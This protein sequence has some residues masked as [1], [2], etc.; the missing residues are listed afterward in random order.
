MCQ[1]EVFFLVSLEKSAMAVYIVVF[2][3]QSL[4]THIIITAMPTGS[5]HWDKARLDFP[6]KIGI[7]KRILARDVF[8]F[9]R[10]TN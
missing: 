10:H 4:S 6:R 8:L 7:S 5:F 9:S 3:A 2:Q 1:E